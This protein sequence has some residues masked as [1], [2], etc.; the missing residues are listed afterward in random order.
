MILE[1]Y[2]YSSWLS[3]ISTV[4]QV[5]GLCRVGLILV[6]H[7][8]RMEVQTTVCSEQMCLFNLKKNEICLFNKQKEC[9]L[10]FTC[11]L[12]TFEQ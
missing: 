4:S 8:S 5:S 1:N 6:L 7:S 10:D 3:A 12:N 11:V 9:Y 2:S